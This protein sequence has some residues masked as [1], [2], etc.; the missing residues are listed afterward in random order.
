MSQ[1]IMNPAL[2]AS[3]ATADTAAPGS[4][5]RAANLTLGGLQIVTAVVFV[6]AAV[7]KVSADPQAVAGFNAIGLGMVGMYSIGLLEIAGAVA[8]LIPLLAGL[9]GLAFTG[10]MVGAVVTT[11][12]VF[13]VDMT[14]LPVVVLVPAG[15]I[16]WGRRQRTVELIELVRSRAHRGR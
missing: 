12:L 7:P 13:G 8:L 5:R 11:L 9:A 1:L 14:A 3:G 15:T 16:A 2:G 6:M 10:L 4:R